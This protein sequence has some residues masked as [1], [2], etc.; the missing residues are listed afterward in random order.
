MASIL[1]NLMYFYWIL[2]SRIVCPATKQRI[3][4]QP[5]KEFTVEWV[6]A[7]FEK[8]MVTSNKPKIDYNWKK[9]RIE[10]KLIYSKNPLE[11]AN[12]VVIPLTQF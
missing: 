7:V 2:P 1:S 5:I 8:L 12:P 9:K 10:M 11:S 4:K 3:N 6:R